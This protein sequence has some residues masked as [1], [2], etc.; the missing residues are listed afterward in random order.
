M[1]IC[2]ELGLKPFQEFVIKGNNKYNNCCKSL[3]KYIF[4]VLDKQDNR[5]PEYVNQSN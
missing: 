1:N 4:K 2:E 3:G 5:E